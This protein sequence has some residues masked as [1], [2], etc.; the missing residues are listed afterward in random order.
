MSKKI[1]AKNIPDGIF[2]LA[3]KR[4]PNSMKIRR[5]VHVELEKILGPIPEKVALAKA[6]RLISRGL[7]AGC[8]CGCRGDFEIIPTASEE[9]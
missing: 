2:L 8:G 5:D 7:I 3:V 4:A 6:R 9:Y 1:Q